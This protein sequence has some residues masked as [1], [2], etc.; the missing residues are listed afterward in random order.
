MSRCLLH[1]CIYGTSYVVSE[2]CEGGDD[3]CHEVGAEWQERC[4][5]YVCMKTTIG[6]Y[7]YFQPIVKDAR[8]WDAYGQ[9]HDPGALF[10]YRLHGRLHNTCRCNITNNKMVYHCY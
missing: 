3:V 6:G 10:T 1:Q 9:C 2:G 7:N 8:C 4:I 5:T